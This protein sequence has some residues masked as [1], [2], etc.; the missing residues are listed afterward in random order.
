ML[1]GVNKDY[2]LVSQKV[3]LGRLPST[4]TQDEQSIQIDITTKMPRKACLIV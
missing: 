4:F 1:R 3:S 2:K